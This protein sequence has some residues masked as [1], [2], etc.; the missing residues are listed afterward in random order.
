MQFTKP[1]IDLVYEIRRRV[2]RERK[3]EVKLANP[4]L[5]PLLAGL[6]GEGRMDSVT[7]ALVK[8]LMHLA[9]ENWS[10][11]LQTQPKSAD[12]SLRMVSRSYRGVISHEQ[13]ASRSDN[14]PRNARIY[15]GALVTG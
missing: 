14:T 12:P 5:L 6:Y 1:M 2:D 15:R 4:E 3:P 8:E 7:K 13:A 11:L 9:G 10:S